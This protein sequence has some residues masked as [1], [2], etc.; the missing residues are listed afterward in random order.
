[1]T[2]LYSTGQGKRAAVKGF[3]TK[4]TGQPSLFDSCSFFFKGDFTSPSDKLPRDKLQKLVELG[5]GE[6]LAREPREMTRWVSL[7]HAV[8]PKK[9]KSPTFIVVGGAKKNQVR[10]SGIHE[11]TGSYLLQCISNFAL[12]DPSMPVAVMRA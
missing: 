3:L 10:E 7:P 2:L 12:D 4:L 1:M 6:V 11:I 8:E 5:N 9:F